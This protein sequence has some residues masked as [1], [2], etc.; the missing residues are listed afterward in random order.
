MLWTG[1]KFFRGIDAFFEELQEKTYKIQNRVMLARYRGRTTCP[2]C[3]GGRLRQEATYV[4]INDQSI[5]DWIDKPIDELDVVVNNLILTDFEQQI[6]DRILVEL[7]TRL[8]TM[9]KVG[10]GYLTLDRLSGTLSGGESQRI[11]LTRLLG[12]NLTSSLYILDEPSI[13]LHPKDTTQL[14]EVLRSLRDLG[15]TV[16]VVEHEEEII[17]SADHIVDIGPYAGD[18]GGELVS[19]EGWPP[20]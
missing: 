12:S 19:V 4:K 5:T 7:R 2:E 17:R 18:H 14:I 10:L 1:N 9:L 15:N 3:D 20:F 6:A 13:G 11:H 16:I 8:R